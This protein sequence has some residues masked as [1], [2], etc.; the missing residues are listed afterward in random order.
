MSLGDIPSGLQRIALSGLVVEAAV[1][2]ADWERVPG[3]RQRLYFDVAAYRA[4]FGRE[5]TIAD[6]FDYSALHAFLLGYER[7]A[8]IDLLETI[9]AE[10]MDFCFQDPAVV[11]AEASVAKPDVFNG[12]GAPSVAIR[13]SRAEWA[14]IRAGSSAP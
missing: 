4:D 2:I 13:A 3:K 11:L 14:R 6:C 1:G 8:H 5:E 9:V 10:V 7:R 12:R